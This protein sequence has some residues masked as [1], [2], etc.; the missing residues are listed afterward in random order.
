MRHRRGSS[1]P[2]WR[3]EQGCRSVADHVTRRGDA[4]PRS[5]GPGASDTGVSGLT[6]ETLVIGSVPVVLSTPG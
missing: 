5:I 6:S 2:R 4:V 3:A 1:S